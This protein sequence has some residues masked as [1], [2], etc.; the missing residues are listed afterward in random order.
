MDVYNALTSDNHN[1]PTPASKSVSFD[2]TVKIHKVTPYNE[3]Y[4]FLPASRVATCN[5]WKVV[6]ARADHYT[7]KSHEIMMTR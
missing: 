3:I 4:G 7:G 2:T 5:G 1:M 6:S